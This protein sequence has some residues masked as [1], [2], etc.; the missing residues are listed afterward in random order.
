MRDSNLKICLVDQGIIAQGTSLKTTGKLN[1]LQELIYSNLVSKYSFEV[2]KLYLESQKLAIKAV[3]DIIDQEQIDCNFE[4]VSSFVF[5]NKEDEVDKIKEEKK[6]LES[7]FIK[8]NEHKNIPLNLNSLYAIS[9]NDTAI[10]HPYKY[11]TKL[12][13]LC[14]ESNVEMYEKT[15]IT[16]IKKVND[17]YI[18][19]SNNYSIKAKK[20]ILACHYPY[21]LRPFLLPLKT[22]IE[23]SYICAANT[24]DYYKNTFITSSLPCKSLRYHKSDKNYIIFLN[25]SHNICNNLN[26]TKNFEQLISEAKQIGINPEYIWSNDDLMT[27]DRIPYIGKIQKGNSDLLL[28][29]GF[30]TWGMTNGTLAGMILSDII[31]GRK[32]K[33]EDMVDPLR[34][35]N[36]KYLNG[37][38]LN[39]S[40]NIKSYVQNYVYKNKQWYTPCVK[41]ESRNG[42]SIAI[43]KEKGNE[44]IVYNKCPHLGCSLIFNE[45]EKTWDC[46]CHASRFNLE[47]KCIKGPSNYNI[48]YKEKN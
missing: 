40:S 11:L 45:I 14:K 46:P 34:V 5:T 44:Y 33:F 37:Y 19:K 20:V 21:F 17:K 47:G 29:T 42:K 15:K 41:F 39:I 12:K 38:L 31:L 26:Y 30:N 1:Y 32:N 4:Q 7:L 27:P 10:F 16:D 13:K 22:Y 18:C 25:G 28:A 3:K 8:V 48:S 6:I 23:K 2:A 24:V 35:N 9:V 36:F 43:Y